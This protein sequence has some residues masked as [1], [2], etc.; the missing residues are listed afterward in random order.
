MLWLLGLEYDEEADYKIPLADFTNHVAWRQ[1]CWISGCCLS[2]RG[3]FLDVATR[4]SGTDALR[5][6]HGLVGSE[7]RG[8][9]LLRAA[10]M[11][12]LEAWQVRM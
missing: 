3:V 7:I 9:D 5:P 8:I 11:R 12:A 6:A 2:L 4:A 10:W 1:F